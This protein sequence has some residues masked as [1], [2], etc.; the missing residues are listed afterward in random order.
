MLLSMLPERTDRNKQIKAVKAATNGGHYLR[1]GTKKRIINRVK[2]AVSLVNS[3]FKDI[4]GLELA[5]FLE[6]MIKPFER[7]DLS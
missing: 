6:T 4:K 3:L 7:T 1:H 5:Y 2:T